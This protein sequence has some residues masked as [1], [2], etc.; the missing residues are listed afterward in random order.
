MMTAPVCPSAGLLT[1]PRSPDR[2]SHPAKVVAVALRGHRFALATRTSANLPSPS[3][4]GEGPG[5]REHRPGR[6]GGQTRPIP[7]T[8]SPS[9]EACRRMTAVVALRAA[10]H[11]RGRRAVVWPL[12][13][14]S[15]TLPS[16]TA[17]GEGP[18]N[19]KVGQRGPF[20]STMRLWTKARNSTATTSPPLAAF[21]AP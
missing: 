5:M 3:A 12:Y 10:P 14:R 20:L 16:P 21:A 2:R 11:A 13:P 19:R 6:T 1:R 18:A 8:P 17:E 7:F 15:L 4:V 9:K